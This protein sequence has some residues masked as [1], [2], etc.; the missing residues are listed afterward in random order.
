MNTK[1][2]LGDLPL[3]KINWINL[4]DFEGLCF[5][6]ARAHLTFNQPIPDFITRN[7]GVLESCLASPLQFFGEKDLYPRFV[8]KLSILFYLMIKNHPFQNGNKR[9]AVATL[10]VVL[11]LNKLWLDTDDLLPYELA[12]EVAKSKMEDRNKILK[13]I[14]NFIMRYTTRA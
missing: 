1:L 4:A 7:P 12:K 11:S 8:D 3:S 9:I 2:L 14:A 13:K 6:L 10:F 5:N